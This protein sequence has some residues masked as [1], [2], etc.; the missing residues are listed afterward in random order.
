MY[1]CVDMCVCVCIPIYIF[2]FRRVVSTYRIKKMSPI[3]RII[4]YFT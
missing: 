1:T 3:E 4:G 2:I